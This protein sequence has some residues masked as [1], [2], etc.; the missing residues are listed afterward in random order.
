M[1]PAAG[2]AMRFE[3]GE[4]WSRFL[5]QVD[6]Q[7]IRAAEESLVQMME[8][9]EAVAGRTFLDAGSGSGLFSLA[10]LRLGATRVH[11]FDYDSRSVATTEEIKRRFA[12]GESRWTIERGDVLDGAYVERLGTW[13]I[14]YS[15]GVLH[16]TGDMWTAI[17][18][19]I[20]LVAPDGSFFLAIYNDQ[21]WKTRLWTY[22]KRLYNANAIGR[23]AVVSVFIPYWV[24]RGAAADLLRFRNP[25]RRYRQRHSPRGMSL[26]RDWIDW[27]GG[28]PFQAASPEAVFRFV[29]ERGFELRN[30]ATYGVGL[31]C[32]EF[33]FRRVR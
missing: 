19:A 27:L 1:Q 5:E 7:R 2:A 24:L 26:M 3:F 18:N 29:R 30:L 17:A 15:W 10:A 4:N 21:G 12:P 28:Y 6:E 13:D 22:V 31:G 9:G 14:V 20:H 16:H 25:L 32:N 23:A 11:S 33:V 8:G